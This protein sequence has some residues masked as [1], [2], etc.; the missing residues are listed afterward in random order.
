MTYKTQEPPIDQG[1]LSGYLSR[2]LRRIEAALGQEKRFHN[3]PIWTTGRG[4][5]ESVVAAP[6]G[7]LYTRLDGGADT[8]LYVK[9]S[10][11]G[12]TGWAAK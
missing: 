4:D 5:P 10:G 11:S 3:G 9:E 12:N 8:T 7:S 2:E 1:A 6:I